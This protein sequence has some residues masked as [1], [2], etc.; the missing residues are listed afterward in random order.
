MR[1]SLRTLLAFED[2]IFDAEHRLQLERT[3]PHHHG[4]AQ[5]LRRIREV[6]H[7][8]RLGVPGI[9]GQREELDPNL[10]AEYL[11]HQL[12][13]E[14]LE[15]FESYCL[16]SDTYLAEIVSVHQILSTVLGEP[17]RTSRECRLRCYDIGRPQLHLAAFPES[18][19]QASPVV[20]KPSPTVSSTISSDI[21]TV[22]VKER[23]EQAVVMEEREVS[24]E[25]P[26]A[27][28]FSHSWFLLLLLLLFLGSFIYWHQTHSEEEKQGPLNEIAALQTLEP[29]KTVAAA[30][31]EPVPTPQPEPMK[32]VAAVAVAEPVPTPQPE[33]AKTVAAVAVAEPVP[34]PQP[35]PAKTVAAA[36]V[37]EPVPTPQPE[38]AKTVVATVP[39][40]EPS[41][42]ISA[43]SQPMKPNVD[44]EVWNE[45]S[46]IIPPA[47]SAEPWK[48]LAASEKPLPAP[49]PQ[50]VVSEPKTA[51]QVL[52]TSP[53]DHSVSPTTE[54]TAPTGFEIPSDPWKVNE[55]NT[56]RQT[57]SIPNSPEPQ[58]SPASFPEEPTASL[59]EPD[60]YSPWKN[61]E[62]SGKWNPLRDE[63]LKRKME[64]PASQ[65]IAAVAAIQEK[66]PSSSSTEHSFASS[67]F[68]DRASVTFP[69]RT[70]TVPPREITATSAANA[71]ELPRREPQEGG[72][73]TKEIAPLN[74]AWNNPGSASR[75]NA[76][77]AS[78]HS[79]AG[80]SGIQP[81]RYDQ[82]PSADGKPNKSLSTVSFG[83][84]TPLANERLQEQLAE[85]RRPQG[86]EVVANTLDSTVLFT[87]PSANEKWRKSTG[88]VEVRAE[89][90][91]LTLA[92]FRADIEL[93]K[94]FRIE[95]VGDS[96][97]CF[98]PPDALG[99]PGIYVDYGRI[100]IHPLTPQARSLH[101]QTENAAGIVTFG[102]RSLVFVDTF[103]GI[104]PGVA[105]P[106]PQA[107]APN[108]STKCNTI[109]GL[110][111]GQTE[112]V[113]WL[114]N[115]QT[116]PLATQTQTSVLLDKNRS[117]RG[118]IRN[119]PTWLQPSTLTPENQMIANACQQA[120]D[121][122]NGNCEGALGLLSQHPSVAVRT[123]GGRLWGDL[124][125]FDVPLTLLTRNNP[126]DEPIRLVLAGYFREAMKRDTETIQRL[127]DAVETEYRPTRMKDVTTHP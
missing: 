101:I 105:E 14:K 60:K 71:Q 8:A 21:Q 37:A 111:P 45:I 108:G 116:K 96:K 27:Q 38:P 54:K 74:D 119:L 100:V 59:R 61:A 32:T 42:T 52:P 24:Q 50:P 73:E 36:V 114:A 5:T 26:P 64:S 84:V 123:F 56:I 9:V 62:M 12:S 47:P 11:D 53:F 85:T 39:F 109:V 110:L 68:R 121:D 33:P 40:P 86:S 10:V 20:T 16:S 75:S 43:V 46:G 88:H 117:E 103:A 18:V 19:P 23:C 25:K 113:L 48:E 2:N 70:A 76:P 79:N 81:T 63:H 67:P 82:E 28:H 87:A 30:V 124:G 57:A 1:L 90:Y 78:N 35:E 104:V 77:I 99:N 118:T 126:E 31:A 97:L 13:A 34:T 112:T 3:I 69:Q 49:I 22:F 125:R 66:E 98:L 127:A 106:S 55:T 4:A 122:T 44:S 6:A 80:L 83:Q 41:T 115:G 95:M 15:Q 72:Q 17:A 91:L 89:Q 120:F 58:R 65:P 51:Q 92:P 107:S 7:N 29:A 93:G 102:G 94:S